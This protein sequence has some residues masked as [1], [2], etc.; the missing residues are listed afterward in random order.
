M[1]L[2]IGVHDRNSQAFER[3]LVCFQLQQ[4]IN[5]ISRKDHKACIKNKNVY[6]N[7]FFQLYCM[8]LNSEED[9]CESIVACLGRKVEK[10]SLEER[11]N[12]AILETISVL[13]KGIQFSSLEISVDVMTDTT[14][15]VGV[16][17]FFTWQIIVPE[18]LTRASLKRIM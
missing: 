5:R 3:R 15:Y 14:A 13:F 18:L 4:H 2:S 6:K 8:I 16:R 7:V 11:F 10:L 9:I 17:L 12:S 1:S